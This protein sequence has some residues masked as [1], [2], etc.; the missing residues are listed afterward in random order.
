MCSPTAVVKPQN[1]NS[2]SCHVVCNDRKGLVLKYLFVSV[3]QSRTAEHYYRREVISFGRIGQCSA[4]LV[5]HSF[6]RK[7]HILTNVVYIFGFLRS[8]DCF[9]TI[10]SYKRKRH[11]LSALSESAAYAV[12]GDICSLENYFRQTKIYTHQKRIVSQTNLFCLEGF[13]CLRW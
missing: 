2:V 3:L 1:S 12:G 10:F 11:R 9:L 13:L 6:N 4:K 5:I 7:N 8:V